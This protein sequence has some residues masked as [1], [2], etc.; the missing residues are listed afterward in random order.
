MDESVIIDA[1]LIFIM[2]RCTQP[3][4]K[5]IKTDLL[6]EFVSITLLL[7]YNNKSNVPTWKEKLHFLCPVVYI[8]VLR[9]FVCLT[10]RV[11][12]LIMLPGF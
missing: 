11:A 10:L 2:H 1:T 3:E 4:D 7:L 8:K 6:V 12:T 9:G 5:K